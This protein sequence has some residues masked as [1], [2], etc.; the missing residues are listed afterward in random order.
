MPWVIGAGAL[1]I[2]FLSFFGGWV[3]RVAK[4][5]NAADAA[6]VA[7]AATEA[8]RADLAA[9]KTEVA[10]NYASNK[11]IEQMEARLV[12]AIERLGDRLDTWVDRVGPRSAPR[13]RVTK[14]RS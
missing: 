7:L 13:T 4:G 10:M 5:E 1:L 3:L 6:R 2:A 12:G 8:V 9:F 14:E 11:M